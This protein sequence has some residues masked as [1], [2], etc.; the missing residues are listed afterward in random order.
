MIAELDDLYER[1]LPLLAKRLNLVHG[2]AH[3]T[4]YWRI[5]AGPWLQHYLHV[6]ADRHTLLREAE[7][8]A[9]GFDTILLPESAYQTPHD[10]ADFCNRSAEDLYNLQLFSQLLRATGQKYSER[11]SA[12]CV[13]ER[14]QTRNTR[15]WREVAERS[16]QGG[17]GALNRARGGGGVALAGMYLGFKDKWRLATAVGRAGDLLEAPSH[18]RVVEVDRA[19]RRAEFTSLSLGGGKIAQLA[20]ELLPLNLPVVLLE[21][22]P[23]LL[24]AVTPL[25]PRRRQ[26]V[27]SLVGWTSIE[28]FKV[29]AAE[30]RAGG[31]RLVAGQHGG[32]YGVARY[33]SSEDHERRVSDA[34]GTWGWAG[35]TRST[36][37]RDVP[38]PKISA[39]YRR[40]RVAADVVFVGTAH[41]RYLYRFQSSPVGS[42]WAEYFEAQ[43]TF[44]RRLS[45]ELRRTI[46]YRPPPDEYGHGYRR[47]M[48][49][50]FPEVRLDPVRDGRRRLLRAAILVVDHNA[51]TLLE[52]LALDIPTIAFWR[53]DRWELR[54]SA[55]PAF[56]AL[57]E[58][59]ILHR[60]PEEAAAQLQRVAAAPLDWWDSRQSRTARTDFMR[61][62]V[63]TS[64]RWA[65]DWAAFIHYET[66]PHN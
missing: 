30:A 20:A 55:E 18:V 62:F 39:L 33:S 7:R 45:E 16:L 31:A 58:A 46:Y 42:Q 59:G 26:G 43:L 38:A 15:S 60:S 61:A 41:P 40:T 65:A 29:F 22:F 21:G 52:A 10:T 36:K 44:Y 56:A 63:L 37:C 27:V 8:L 19:R 9:P 32:C 34:Y 23:A 49:K 48:L 12:P 66:G 6:L 1:A 50:A 13:G 51:T 54:E 2:L 14:K 35:Q 3:D 28:W 4:E 24:A 5:V 25:Q 47:Q 53:E 64:P 11:V 57:R 17:W